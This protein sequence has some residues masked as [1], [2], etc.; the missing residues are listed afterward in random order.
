MNGGGNI[1]K[2]VLRLM[3]TSLIIFCILFI[4]IYPV[5]GAFMD[6]E[7][8]QN[9]KEQQLIKKI[10]IIHEAFP[11]QIDPV[12]LYATVS[13]RPYF[14]GYVDEAYDKNFDAEQYE[15]TWSGFDNA[16][17]NLLSLFQAGVSSITI[18]D[19]SK[20][21]DTSIAKEITTPKAVDL[22][23]AATIVM[24]DSSGWT[25]TYSDENYQKALA[26]DSL[27]GSLLY[28]SDDQ[29]VQKFIASIYNGAFCA[30]GA[31]VDVATG[32]LGVDFALTG[33][34]ATKLQE[35]EATSLFSNATERAGRYYTMSNIC[36]NGFI[37]GTYPEAQNIEDEELN[38]AK[39]DKI[40]EEII[41]YAERL[42][43]LYGSDDCIYPT[44]TGDA[45]NWRQYSGSW[46]SLTLGSGGKTVSAAGCT[47]TSMAYLIQKSGTS[48]LSGNF[49]PGVFV[50]NASYQ[51]SNLVWNSWQSVAPNFVMDK[52]NVSI[53]NYN[54]SSVA[55]V[56]EN[57]LNTASKGLYQ[58]F[59]VIQI[60]GHWIAV[61]HIENG[62]VYVFDPAAEEGVGLVTLD[63]A[64]NRGGKHR[65]LISYNTFYATDVAFGSTGPSDSSGS[66]SS[67]ANYCGGTADLN[68]FLEF[69]AYLEGVSTCNYHGRGDGTGYS[70]NNLGDGAGMTTAFGITQ[71]YS[72][73]AASQ[74]GYASFNADIS[75]GC[76]DKNYI[77][78]M[79]PLIMQSYIDYVTQ[80]LS[81]A[82]LNQ[83]Q[84]YT[85]A[86]V[87]YNTGQG[88]SYVDIA[89]KIKNN[90]ADSFEVFDCMKTLGCGWGNS[91][92]N[93]GLVSRRMAEY[94]AFK[95]G[96]FNAE[97]P[98]KGYSYF[99]SINTTD[100]WQNY[101]NENWPTNRY[102]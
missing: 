21:Y 23:T 6:E 96:N 32:G 31:F 24:L 42:R 72:K 89:N 17:N 16:F 87:V 66:N 29:Y 81:S 93:D 28:D 67:S 2:K 53:S 35:F 43:E 44:G 41:N 71:N 9:K 3:V 80:D 60:T 62:T 102:E 64:L 91:S 97:K 85:M 5:N 56:I 82:G 8:N 48:L 30:A 68:A 74:V 76:T 54:A 98:S 70:A 45:T 83:A 77:D 88:G 55:S 39:K 100:K 52:Q 33:F 49:D 14:T 36:M 51:S 86:S 90:G 61:D 40:A 26:G 15:N 63:T 25:G 94:E 50:Q 46:A 78:Q 4:N 65:S 20:T 79:F 7:N 99:A 10:E 18:D 84:I 1:I 73:G 59:V 11:N 92:Y 95:T 12:A 22:L 13:Y 47:S 101:M 37:G 75:S 38:Q 57:E 34:D 27:V 69:V 58:P 19:P